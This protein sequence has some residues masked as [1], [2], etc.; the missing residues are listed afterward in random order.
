MF[1][2]S[3]F[4]ISIVNIQVLVIKQFFLIDHRHLM[5]I[6]NQSQIHIVILRSIN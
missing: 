5:Y 3:L 6:L 1:I 2:F 4:T